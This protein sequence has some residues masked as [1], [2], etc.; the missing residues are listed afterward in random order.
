[1]WYLKIWMNYVVVAGAVVGVARSCWT[2][3]V[4][5]IIWPRSC[6]AVSLKGG[7]Q[8]ETKEEQVLAPVDEK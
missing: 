7:L 4:T 5:K 6:K 3:I 8:H 1:M 2:S